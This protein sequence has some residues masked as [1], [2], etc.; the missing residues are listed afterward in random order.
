PRIEAEEHYYNPKHTALI[1]LGLKPNYLTDEAIAQMIEF[2]L[3]Y[4]NNIVLKQI[5]QNIKWA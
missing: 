2:T 4:K 3:K 1:D 5:H